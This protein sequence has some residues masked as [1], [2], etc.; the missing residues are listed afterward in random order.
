MENK[1]QH[2]GYKDHEE[3]IEKTETAIINII[4][5]N[6]EQIVDTSIIEYDG[7]II[8]HLQTI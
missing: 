6:K 5:A 3:F 8:I 4:E 2:L 1:E 7:V